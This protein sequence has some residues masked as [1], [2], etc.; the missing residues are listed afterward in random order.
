MEGASRT[1]I[2]IIADL[3]TPHKSDITCKLTLKYP[4]GPG[5]VER[6]KWLDE[7]VA[8]EELELLLSPSD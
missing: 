5:D 2:R 3:I 4:R 8:V 6:N 1:L 7:M